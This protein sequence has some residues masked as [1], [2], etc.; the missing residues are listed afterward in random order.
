MQNRRLHRKPDD[1]VKAKQDRFLSL[2]APPTG[3]ALKFP[4]ASTIVA[5][6]EPVQSVFRVVSGYVR[7]CIYTEEGHRRIVSFHGAGSVVGMSQLS[8]PDWKVSVEAVTSCVLD[9]VP[10]SVIEDRMDSE[11]DVREGALI[12]LH[13]DVEMREA[14]LVMMAI[15]PATERLHAFL[16]CFAKMRGSDGLVALPMCRRDIGDYLGLSMETVSRSFSALRESER[17]ETCGAEKFRLTEGRPFETNLD[18]C[19]AA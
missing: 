16:E 12:T 6:G 17:I 4:A 2:F 8:S 1:V 13:S 14:H 9:A 11:R 7:L 5:Q 18:H 10:K 15:L 3:V 19:H